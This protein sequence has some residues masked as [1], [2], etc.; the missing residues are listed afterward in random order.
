MRRGITSAFIETVNQIRLEFS[1][2]NALSVYNIKDVEV[3]LFYEFD[4][5]TNFENTG[6]SVNSHIIGA[7]VIRKF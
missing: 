1:V 3:T 4:D 7:E 2:T 6:S 5:I